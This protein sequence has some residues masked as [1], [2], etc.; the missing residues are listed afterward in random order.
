MDIVFVH[1]IILVQIGIMCYFIKLHQCIERYFA[2]IPSTSL[3]LYHHVLL[4]PLILQ[5]SL[6]C[7]LISLSVYKHTCINTYK[8][9]LSKPVLCMRE[10]MPSLSFF[11]VS[12]YLLMIFILLLF[13]ILPLTLE[14]TFLFIYY[15]LFVY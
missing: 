14:S 9:N 5:N 7:A 4:V 11:V 3:V 12:K 6:A 15:Y 10:C 13:R 8:T 2:H 1:K